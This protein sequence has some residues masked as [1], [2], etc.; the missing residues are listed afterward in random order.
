[1]GRTIY[2]GRLT[3]ISKTEAAIASDPALPPLSNLKIE[4]DEVSGSNPAGE[5]YAKVVSVI[6]GT[7][8]QARFRFTSVSPDLKLWVRRIAAQAD[9]EPTVPS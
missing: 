8:P 7:P 6:P 2:E 9:A 5:I 1:M 4:L 3:S